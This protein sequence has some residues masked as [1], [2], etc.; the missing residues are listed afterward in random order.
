MPSLSLWT[1]TNV[2]EMRDWLVG[3]DHAKMEHSIRGVGKFDIALLR[4]ESTDKK[5]P[6]SLAD[7][8]GV[9][10][11]IYKSPMKDEKV[12]QLNEAKVRSLGRAEIN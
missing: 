1:C 2:L 4:R 11:I 3:W 5:A 9:V 7:L 8:A 10:E 12:K 6:A